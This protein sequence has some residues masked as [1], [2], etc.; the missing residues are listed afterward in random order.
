MSQSITTNKMTYAPNEDSDHLGI[1]PVW[2]VLAVHF[3]GS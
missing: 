2:T 1:H 3:M